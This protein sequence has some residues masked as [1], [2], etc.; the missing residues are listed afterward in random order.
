MA[1]A[2]TG[3]RER[4]Q[5]RLDALI[6]RMEE[7]TEA[8]EELS[9]GW[10]R[11]EARFRSLIEQVDTELAAYSDVAAPVIRAAQAGSVAA[12]GSHAEALTRA[13]LGKAPAEAVASVA[14]NKLPTEAV[15]TLVGFASDGSPLRD[16]LA[17]IEPQAR[18]RL[19]RGLVEGVATGRNPRQIARQVAPGIDGFR[20]RVETI[21]RT[22]HMRAYREAS[23]QSYLANA[24][25]VT[26][27]TWTSAADRRTCPACFAMHGTLHTVDEVLDDHPRGRCSMAPSV[28]SLAE[29]VGDPSIP[30]TRPVIAKG[31]DLFA[32]LP[33]EQQ[34]E[35]LGPL[36]EPWQAGKIPFSAFVTQDSDPR[37]GTMRRASSVAEALAAAA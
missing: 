29:I 20:H 14:W 33:A 22:E 21:A 11:Q 34:Q 12:A 1:D 17:E 30:D 2:Y 36:Y 3:V 9:E 37:W 8:G 23:R 25:T 10:L 4:L 35:I 19:E 24:D 27:W 26:G 7:A 18:E 31:E 5:E 15:E 16:L 6:Q 13:A 28:R 32:A